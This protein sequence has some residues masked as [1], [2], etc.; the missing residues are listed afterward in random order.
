L[1]SSQPSKNDKRDRLVVNAEGSVDLSL[2]RK[3]PAGKEASGTATMPRRGWFALFRLYG[4]LEPWFDK[5]YRLGEFEL[6]Q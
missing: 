5:E 4:P 2:G 3:P 6:L 1:Q